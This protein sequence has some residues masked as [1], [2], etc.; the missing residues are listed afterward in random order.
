MLLSSFH[1]VK[2]R[3][4]CKLARVRLESALY[5]RVPYYRSF[6]GRTLWPNFCID[7]NVGLV[8]WNGYYTVE[9][10]YFSCIVDLQKKYTISTVYRPFQ[11]TKPTFP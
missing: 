6:I 9:M 8:R 4:I 2:K 10:M 11:L 3:S 5:R 1:E 7:E